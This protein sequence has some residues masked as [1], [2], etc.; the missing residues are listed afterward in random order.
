MRPSFHVIIIAAGLALASC[1]S[2]KQ[3]SQ[4]SASAIGFYS[5]FAEETQDLVKSLPCEWT[6]G[7][8]APLEGETYDFGCHGGRWGSVSLLVDAADHA[9][10]YIERVRLIWRS[11]D[12]ADP[13][14]SDADVAS[15]FVREITSRFVAPQI[16]G[17][18]E[19]SFMSGD[20]K[21]W[22]SNVA[23]LHVVSYPTSREQVHRLEIKLRDTL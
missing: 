22:Q 9:P 23:E 6:H 1:T 17:E 4:S 21:A 20:K 2:T 5:P 10:D 7:Q 16:A 12:N 18:I 8:A 13:R 11:W 14:V 19:Q 15:F 3:A